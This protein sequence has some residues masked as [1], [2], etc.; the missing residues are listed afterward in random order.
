MA[1]A[2]PPTLRVSASSFVS[3]LVWN[4]WILMQTAN[5]APLR[6]RPL[7]AFRRAFTFSLLDLCF[8]MVEVGGSNPP[9]PTK[10]L[11]RCFYSILFFRIARFSV[12]L[13]VDTAAER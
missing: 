4:H 11:C 13:C 9:G 6:G 5:V 12:F 2:T 8:D 3:K 1:W 10:F 7:L